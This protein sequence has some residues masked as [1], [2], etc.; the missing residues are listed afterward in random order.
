MMSDSQ[1]S[2]ELIQDLIREK[3]SEKRWKNIRF[4]IGL[5]LIVTIVFLLGTERNL[6]SLGVSSDD[7]NYV[8]FIRLEGMI[9]PGRDFSAQEVLP[10]LK[11][12]FSD[13]EAKGVVIDINS[14]GG[15]PV[16]ASIIHDA[17]IELKKKYNKK[18]VVV[19]EDI[20]A[21]GAYY[22]AVAADKI[23]VNPNTLTGSIGVIMKGFG[24]PELI[25]KIGV[26]RR[27]Y[28]SGVNK[29]RL[30]PFLPQNPEDIEKIRTVIGEVH[31]NFNQVVLAGRAGKLHADA[32]DLFT[33]DFWS[34]QTALKLGLVDA[35]GN[36]SNALH[37]E[38]KVSR[39]RDYSSTQ[40]PLKSFMSQFGM[41]L[42]LAL[43]NDG[44][45]LLEKL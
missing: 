1:L 37:D 4:F 11:D 21:S 26:E 18:V 9:E 41:A 40:G 35:L 22:V 28:A 7:K 43:T 17:I 23:Y 31:D 44:V 13:K 25:N 33:G 38:F 20:M 15:T 34:G 5:L 12:A 14:G 39:Y 2:A 30:D 29:D 36:L 10:R 3:R 8:S 16:Q 42:N 27:V 45:K 24:F 6:V 19:G 32:K